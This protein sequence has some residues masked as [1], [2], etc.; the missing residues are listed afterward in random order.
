MSFTYKIKG[1]EA[2]L[3]L[4]SLVELLSQPERV[5]FEPHLLYPRLVGMFLAR[6]FKLDVLSST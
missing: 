1:F 4:T 6:R 5:L 3:E 2:P